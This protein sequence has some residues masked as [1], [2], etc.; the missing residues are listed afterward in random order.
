MIWLSGRQVL[1]WTDPCRTIPL[2]DHCL[3]GSTGSAATDQVDAFA[4]FDIE[5]DHNLVVGFDPQCGVSAETNCRPS[6]EVLASGV[7]HS[8]N[9]ASGQDEPENFGIACG[10]N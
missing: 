10:M 1:I 5:A 4:G 7:E 8:L 2:P 6:S 9:R 3:P